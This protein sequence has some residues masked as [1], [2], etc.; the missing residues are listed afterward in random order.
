MVLHQERVRAMEKEL[1]EE[2]ARARFKRGPERARPACIATR[3][4]G[5]ERP[6]VLG[7]VL[8]EMP[9][10]R[11]ARDPARGMVVALI[12]CSAR[13]TETESMPARWGREHDLSCLRVAWSGRATAWRASYDSVCP[14]LSV[15][16]AE[17]ARRQLK[18]YVDRGFLAG[19]S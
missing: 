9:R 17:A 12:E 8:R 4:E 15:R 10:A 11:D 18:D 3:A 19:G 5:A 7:F 16:G 14:S 6:V 13:A 2:R 1:S